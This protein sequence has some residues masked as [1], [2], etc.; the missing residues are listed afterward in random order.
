M[1]KAHLD[2]LGG[3]HDSFSSEKGIK[4][5]DVQGFQRCNEN[6]ELDFFYFGLIYSLLCRLHS[7]SLGV[8]MQNF[9]VFYVLG[10]ELL[11]LQIV[12]KLSPSSGSTDRS[13]VTK[14]EG[15][16]PSPL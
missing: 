13:D 7:E 1:K 15:N 8:L 10:S 5:I 4:K 6:Q 11:N 14:L 16:N 9:Q 2:N 3:M 12:D